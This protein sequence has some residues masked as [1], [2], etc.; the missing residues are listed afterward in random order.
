[1]KRK[2]TF[3]AWLA[4]VALLTAACWGGGGAAEEVTSGPLAYND[5]PVPPPVE[6]DG[7]E[8]TGQGG[9]GDGDGEGEQVV[10]LTALPDDVT[11]GY[12]YGSDVER[13]ATMTLMPSDLG[14]DYADLA[15]DAL[16]TGEVGNAADVGYA[17]DEVGRA[18]LLGRDGRRTGYRTTL[19]MHPTGE[20]ARAVGT[21]TLL[22]GDRPA[23]AVVRTEVS[24]FRGEAEATAR[25]ADEKEQW[26]S[27]R[28]AFGSASGIERID[29]APE[30]PGDAFV[31]ERMDGDEDTGAT[32]IYFSR[33]DTVA[34]VFVG[35]V[36][37]AEEAHHI[38]EHM[39][40]RVWQV[41]TG[42]VPPRNPQSQAE[43]FA[44]PHESLDRFRAM[45]EIVISD[46]KQVQERWEA[47]GIFGG[48]DRYHCQLTR[49][50]PGHEELV[51]D[52]LV[53][54]NSA[55][56]WTYDSFQTVELDTRSA[57]FAVATSWCPARE[58]VW[59]NDLALA[60]ERFAVG[61]AHTAAGP[62]TSYAAVGQDDLDLVFGWVLT[63]GTELDR[64]VQFVD[65]DGWLVAQHADVW[66][67]RPVAED[68]FGGSYQGSKVLVEQS[69]RVFDPDH[70][71]VVVP[72]RFGVGGSAVIEVG[73]TVEF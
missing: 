55:W 30:F 23:V 29:D 11:G 8:E 13:A 21:A 32:I 46:G 47:E 5:I 62:A 15:A 44:L 54:G 65:E 36:G 28:Q 51:S 3:S 50:R 66:Y 42:Q 40:A 68:L 24:L 49:Y 7:G 45:S 18:A 27:V 61:E 10:D 31:V 6:G 1:M 19:V 69:L 17:F 57:E 26:R 56:L 73:E 60:V 37:V 9:D 71:D 63:S 64:F 59:R 53:D 39:V 48:S 33:D 58:S 72:E 41:Q 4:T 52:V 2:R 12:T 16:L 14:D 35:G 22:A 25:L 67:P 20:A 43:G 38:A 34:A 70:E